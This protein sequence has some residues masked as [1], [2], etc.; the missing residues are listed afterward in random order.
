MS[1]KSPSF[2]KEITTAQPEN[3]CFQN[4]FKFLKIEQPR[5]NNYTDEEVLYELEGKKEKE[6]NNYPDKFVNQ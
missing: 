5:D 4:S 2:Y 1:I 6:K 3:S